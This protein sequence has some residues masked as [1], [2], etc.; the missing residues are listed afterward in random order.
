MQNRLDNIQLQE[1]QI[2]GMRSRMDY[3]RT[4]RRRI[5]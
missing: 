5:E 2:A 3:L 4:L 1:E